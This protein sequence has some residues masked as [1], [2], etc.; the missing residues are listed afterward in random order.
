M[1]WQ[2][3]LTMFK[4]STYSLKKGQHNCERKK[5]RRL[6]QF[7]TDQ[8]LLGEG[9]YPCQQEVH[10]SGVTGEIKLPGYPEKDYQGNSRCEWTVTVPDGLVIKKLSHLL[11]RKSKKCKS[12]LRGL[13][14]DPSSQDTRTC[15]LVLTLWGGN[16]NFSLR[17]HPCAMAWGCRSALLFPV[18]LSF[19]TTG[20]PVGFALSNQRRE[21]CRICFPMQQ[22][23]LKSCFLFSVHQIWIRRFFCGIPGSVRIRPPENTEPCYGPCRHVLRWCASWSSGRW[24]PIR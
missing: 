23:S 17:Q 13:A 19:K 12:P 11:Q 15:A 10:L 4:V 24:G 7:P 18:N 14:R 1:V 21:M 2:S 5:T 3:L 8:T 22:D 9:P 20:T 16:P 6:I